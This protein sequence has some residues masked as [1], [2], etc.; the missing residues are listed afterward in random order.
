MQW[1]SKESES[2]RILRQTTYHECN[3]IPRTIPKRSDQTAPRKVKC[4]LSGRSPSFNPDIYKRRNAVGR[5]YARL[6]A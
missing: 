2:S 6:W 5:S 3:C 4:S 1:N